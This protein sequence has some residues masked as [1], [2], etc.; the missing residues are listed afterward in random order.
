[1]ATT[2][3]NQ[4]SPKSTQAQAEKRNARPS[5]ES[6]G[7]LDSAAHLLD[8]AVESAEASARSAIEHVQGAR[9][10]A[11]SG[12]DRQQV[13][14]SGQIRDV[15]DALRSSSRKLS[16]SESVSSLLNVASEQAEKL[17]AYVDTATPRSV[18]SDLHQFARE[19]PGW[20]FGG[21]FIAGLTLGRFAKSSASASSSGGEA[22]SQR[23]PSHAID[24]SSASQYPAP[25]AGGARDDTSER[26]V[27]QASAPSTTPGTASRAQSSST[28][29]SAPSSSTSSSTP[30]SR[31]SSTN[32]A[33]VKT[34]G[35]V[36]VG[37]STGGTKSPASKS[38]PA[39]KSEKPG[40][41]E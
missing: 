35:N 20:F 40:T 41:G 21:A 24:R 37:D 25:R 10:K 1:M 19:R 14:L 23:E 38:T 18:A 11:R 2:T 28:A 15:G 4:D 26:A 30:S 36:H 13:Q 12:L 27:A 31:P 39:A 29:S 32:A 5:P 33:P 9:D 34:A 22:D 3:P 16:D 17:A 8:N 7:A 6:E